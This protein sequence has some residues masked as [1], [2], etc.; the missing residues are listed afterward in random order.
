VAL[1]SSSAPEVLNAVDEHWW[2]FRDPL[3]RHGVRIRFLCPE[4]FRSDGRDAGR[5]PGR[6][7]NAP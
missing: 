7:R 6:R 2:R 5:D 4:Q 3:R 1:A